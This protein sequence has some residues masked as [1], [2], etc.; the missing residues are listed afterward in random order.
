[1]EGALLMTVNPNLKSTGRVLEH[2]TNDENIEVNS[3]YTISERSV[4]LYAASI[5]TRRRREK[6]VRPYHYPMNKK[7]TTRS[8]RK[9]ILPY[10]STEKRRK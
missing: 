4:I 10:S 7:R 3:Y 5:M 8:K 2:G 9:Q 1:M 6:V